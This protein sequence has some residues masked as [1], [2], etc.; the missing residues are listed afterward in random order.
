MSTKQKGKQSRI[1]EFR[2]VSIGAPSSRSFIKVNGKFKRCTHQSNHSKQFRRVAL[3]CSSA[4]R[5]QVI[6]KAKTLRYTARHNK[7]NTHKH[8]LKTPARSARFYLSCPP[9]DCTHLYTTISDPIL[10]F[11]GTTLWNNTLDSQSSMMQPQHTMCTLTVQLLI[12]LLWLFAMTKTETHNTPTTQKTSRLTAAT[13]VNV[14][15][16]EP[17]SSRLTAATQGVQRYY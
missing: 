11:G 10:Q 14:T 5:V 16:L 4:G 15:K 3:R 6:S 13:P 2:L 9:N 12:P 17:T 7:H 8:V 1:L